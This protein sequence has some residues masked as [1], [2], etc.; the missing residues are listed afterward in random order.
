MSLPTFMEK[1]ISACLIIRNEAGLLERCLE[2]LK[3]AVDEII[4]IH[5]GECEDESLEIARRF[6]ARV[7]KRPEQGYMEAYLP[8]AL[9]EAR[10]DWILRIDADEYLSPELA[11]SLRNLA[12]ADFS[13]YSFFDRFGTEKRKLRSAG[14]KKPAFLKKA[15][16]L[17]SPR[18][19]L[20]SG[21][22]AKPLNPALPCATVRITIT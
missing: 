9:R 15:P 11:G 4:I 16:F 17:L 22:P 8:F 19:T 14:R 6:K 20:I 3:K 10:G 21:S 18:R 5:D 7:S 12:A 2:S 13:A 1:F